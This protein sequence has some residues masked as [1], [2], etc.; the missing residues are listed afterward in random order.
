VIEVRS[1]GD[2]SYDKLPFFAKLGV[3]EVVIVDRDSKRI[4]VFHLPSGQYLQQEPDAEGEVTSPAL[5]VGLRTL[6]AEPP[7]LRVRDT[8]GPGLSVEI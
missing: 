6:A 3:T 2:E 1:P 8:A 7:R 5:G 4:D